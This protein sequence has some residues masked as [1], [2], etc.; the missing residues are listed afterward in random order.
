VCPMPRG[1]EFRYTKKV[2]ILLGATISTLKYQGRQVML[3]ILTLWIHAHLLFK[4]TDGERTGAVVLR[5]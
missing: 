5:E 4:K 1:S 2:A 3:T